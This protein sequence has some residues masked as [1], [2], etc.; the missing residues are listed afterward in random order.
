MNR[1]DGVR[2]ID[3][4]R[5]ARAPESCPSECAWT[6]DVFSR[7]RQKSM[8]ELGILDGNKEAMGSAA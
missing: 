4:M 7:D 6:A 2:L 8:G 5:K 1:S 3:E